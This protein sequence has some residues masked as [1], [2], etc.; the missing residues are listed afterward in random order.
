MTEQREALEQ[1]TAT[2][3]VLQVINASPGDLGPVFETML[4]RAMRLCGTA[5]GELHTFDGERF[6]T[7]AVQGV[8]AAYA[9]IRMHNPTTPDPGTITE[10]MQVGE[11]VVPIADLMATETY[12]RGDPQRRT[13]VGLGGA[14]AVLAVALRERRIK[15]GETHLGRSAL[16]R[17]PVYV[18]D[19]QQDPSMPTVS[20]LLAGIHAVMAVP[21]LRESKVIGGMVIR[22][23]TI[24]DFAPTIATLLQTFAG[25]SVLAIENARLFQELAA[26]GEEASRAR[27]AAE[28]T[29][30]D[31]R[32]RRARQRQDMTVTVLVVDDEPAAKTLF[33]QHCHPGRAALE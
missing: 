26:R 11:S 20:A 31:L 17:A 33:R 30:A 24:G 19:L 4:D 22:R 16:L 3:K 29:L 12:Q 14:R 5:F 9:E 15:L 1:Q 8:P 7:A 28:T 32:R 25:Q 27:V 13:L 10:R 18:S 23:R 2:A 6:E 21:L